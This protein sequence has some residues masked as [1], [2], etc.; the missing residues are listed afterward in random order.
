MF[1]FYYHMFGGDIG[2]LDVE[3]TDDSG[4]TWSNIAS[5][6]GP[7]QSAQVD[8]F[9]LS[10]S[11]LIGYSGVVQFR[12]IAT[13]NGTYQGDICIDD[14]A[15]SEAPTCPGP[16]NLMATGSGLTSATFSWTPGLS[17]TQWT[18]EYGAPGFTPGTGTSSLTNNNINETVSGL[19]SNQFFEMYV[20]AA[21]SPGDTSR[22]VGPILFNTFNQGLYMDF[23]RDCPA[24]GFIDIS[25]TGTELFLTDEGVAGITIPFS[26]LYQGAQAISDVS[27]GNNGFIKLGTLTGNT[28]ISGN[29]SGLL[30]GL[31]PWLDDFDTETGGVFYETIGTP[32]NQVFIVQWHQR[33]NY[34]GSA[35]D[36]NV[37]FQVQIEEA[38][39]EIYYVYDD[40]VFGGGFASD[41]YGANADIGIAGSNQDINISN[42][43]PQF[44][45]DN[46]CVHF[47]HTDCPNPTNFTLTT[48]S[49]SDAEITWDPGLASETNWTIIYG[50]AGFDP[51]VSGTSITTGVNVALLTGLT[52]IIHYDVYIF[53]DCNP[54]TLQSTGGLFGTFATLPDCSDITGLNAATAVD[55][56]FI[57]W[58]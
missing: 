36:P 19:P 41:D 37:T 49:T 1:S 7:Q 46:S 25:S 38:T 54:G 24:G 56:L 58:S 51:A 55:S 6:S 22:Y 23:S 39:G 5:L 18:M 9:L 8:P 33:C 57:D 30:D 11:L 50:P 45:T 16:T 34:V 42:N 40:A 53:A 44:L 21:C 14:V 17:E 43:D 3:I 27:I 4:L 20:R 29:M 26:F 13:A 32:G 48:V 31:Y 12:F 47:F 10:E 28:S 52:G 2:D 15:V 35:G